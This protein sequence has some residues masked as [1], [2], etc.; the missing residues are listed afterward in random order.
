MI[1]L[2]NYIVEFHECSVPLGIVIEISRSKDLEKF[3]FV[4]KCYLFYDIKY[5]YSKDTIK[6][7][8]IDNINDE[9]LKNLL[10]NST[11]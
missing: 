11:I 5:G 2:E 1:K 10:K 9:K 7:Y 4:D 6:Q 8:V 3:M